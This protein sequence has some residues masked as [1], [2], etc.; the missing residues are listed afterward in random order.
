[1]TKLA[2]SLLGRRTSLSLCRESRRMGWLGVGSASPE[3]GEKVGVLVRRSS[4]FRLY[5]GTCF[6]NSSQSSVIALV[7]P[8]TSRGCWC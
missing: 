5:N 4:S 2:L 1:M 3:A 6:F 8:K 7:M